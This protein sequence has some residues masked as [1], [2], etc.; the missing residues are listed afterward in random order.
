ME[1]K[2]VKIRRGNNN[3]ITNVYEFHKLCFEQSDHWYK[4]M[5]EQN[6][7]SS[8]V[9]EYDNNIIGVLLYSEITACDNSDIDNLEIIDSNYTNKQFYFK[10]FNGITMLCIHPDYRKKGLS[11]KLIELFFDEHKN[12]I[13]C[14]H[15]RQSN[16]AYNLY[17]KMNF[18]HIANIKD[19]YF[20]P[21]EASCFMIKQN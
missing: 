21:N 9:I 4:K 3:D 18:I 1:K 14:L 7:D 10:S 13:L 2:I 15:T 8:Y 5:I 16:N 19:K 20:F 11:K 17:L 6:I 12:Q